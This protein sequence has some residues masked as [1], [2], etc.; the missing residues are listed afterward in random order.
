MLATWLSEYALLAT[1]A[2]DNPKQILNQEAEVLNLVLLLFVPTC[3]F[4][5]KHFFTFLRI[6]CF[7]FSWKLE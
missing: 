4:S 1:L 6:F 5:L 3:E 7:F 2:L